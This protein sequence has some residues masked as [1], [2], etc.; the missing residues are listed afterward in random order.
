LQFGLLRRNEVFAIDGA[1]APIRSLDNPIYFDKTRNME[2]SPTDTKQ[3]LAAL[4][5]WCHCRPLGLGERH[6]FFSFEG[7]ESCWTDYC[8]A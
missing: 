5:G 2:T 4:A 8:G 6:T 1:G 7:T 3:A